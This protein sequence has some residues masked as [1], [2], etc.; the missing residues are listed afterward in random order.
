MLQRLDHMLQ[1]NHVLIAKL[2]PDLSLYCFIN[3]IQ[4]LKR[5]NQAN[6]TEINDKFIDY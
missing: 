5:Q 4:Q 3:F 6:Q 2:G 1:S